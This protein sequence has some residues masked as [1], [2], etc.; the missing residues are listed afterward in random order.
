M[1]Y[2]L[3][4]VFYPSVCGDRLPGADWK[5]TEVNTVLLNDISRLG[6][7]SYFKWFVAQRKVFTLC[8]HKHV[9]SLKSCLPRTRSS[10]SQNRNS[11]YVLEEMHGL[12]EKE[13]CFS[14]RW[15]FCWRKGFWTIKITL[16][17]VD[18]IMGA[19]KRKKNVVWCI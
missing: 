15:A 5:P 13:K 7:G 3:F 10:V 11:V 6:I 19:G 1:A 17:E 14:R 4:W 16:V 18:W 12:E 8:H 9:S 2:N